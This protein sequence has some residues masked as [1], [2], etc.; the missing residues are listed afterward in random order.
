M[1]D[2]IAARSIILVM[3]LATSIIL[4]LLL[5]VDFF[6]RGNG[7]LE[8]DR[9]LV[10]AVICVLVRVFVVATVRAILP[11][12]V[13]LGE[14]NLDIIVVYDPMRALMM[15]FVLLRGNARI[16]VPIALLLPESLLFV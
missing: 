8:V 4:Q 3:A 7:V 14:V 5:L 6:C 1:G 10:L 15:A 11:I 16:I 13:I 9:D 2:I 12:V